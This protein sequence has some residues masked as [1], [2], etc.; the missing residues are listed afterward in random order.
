MNLTGNFAHHGYAIE[1]MQNFVVSLNS[2]FSLYR[3]RIAR[4]TAGQRGSDTLDAA[5]CDEGRL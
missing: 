3:Q 5:N 4:W 1:Q 2:E